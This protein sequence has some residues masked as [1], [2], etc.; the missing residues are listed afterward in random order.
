METC[1]FTDSQD[2]GTTSQKV[3]GVVIGVEGDEVRT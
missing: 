3:L 1:E 2:F